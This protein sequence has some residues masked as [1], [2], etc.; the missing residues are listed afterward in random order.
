M[1]VACELDQDSCSLSQI[2][3]MRMSHFLLTSQ[4]VYSV[5]VSC[6]FKKPRKSIH[7]LQLCN[8]IVFHTRNYVVYLS[9]QNLK[10]QKIYFK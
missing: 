8:R 3:S 7:S 9:L 2:A 10:M 1:C 6:F 5:A 4:V